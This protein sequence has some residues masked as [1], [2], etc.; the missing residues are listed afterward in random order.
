VAGATG[1]VL[2]A[3]DATTG[4]HTVVYEEVGG[5]SFALASTPAQTYGWS[6]FA[7]QGSTDGPAAEGPAV[8]CASGPEGQ[9]GVIDL[10]WDAPTTN[11]DGS[12]LTDL[13]H[14]RL[15]IGP[16]TPGCPGP[17]YTQV[18]SATPAPTPGTTVQYQVQ[19]LPWG[20][21]QTAQV[22]AV[23]VEGRES[24]CSNQATALPK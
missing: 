7:R 4:G 20:Q 1:Y 23:D 2:Y 21:T 13:D 6:V 8:T 11:A 5:T 10:E 24:P 3:Y 12:P 15:Y 14:Y 18:P 17:S 9:T 19:Q 22:T 16:V